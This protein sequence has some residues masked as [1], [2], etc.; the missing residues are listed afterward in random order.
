VKFQNLVE[1]T[2]L[3]AWKI[4]IIDDDED[5]CLIAKNM[6]AEAKGRKFL[7][8]WASTYEAGRE[9]L[10]AGQ[11]HAALVDYDLGLHSGIE[12]I[13]EANERGYPAPLILFTGRG[14]YE[15]D[16]EAMQAGATLYLTKTEVNSYLLERT[17]RYAI[18]LKQKEQALRESEA[19]LRTSEAQER[20][21]V[22]EMDALLDA[23][24]ALVW[25]TH[26]SKARKISGNRAGN[27]FLRGPAGE[28]LSRS[29]SEEAPRNFRVLK[30]N[31]ELAP[32]ELPLQLAAATGRPIRNFEEEL[33][34]EDGRKFNLLGNATPLLGEDGNPRGAVSAFI[35]ITE[36]KQMEEALQRSEK[37]FYTAFVASP[38]AQV[39]SRQEDGRIETINHSFEQ[40][41]GY[42]REEVIGKTS[43]ELKMFANPSDREEAVRR[44]RA[45]KSLRDFDVDIQTKSGQIR[46]ASLSIEI[47]TIG[48][49]TFM[50]TVL[51]DITGRKHLE[52]RLRAS[53]ERLADFLDSTRDTFFV[54]DRDWCFTYVNRRFCEM[55]GHEPQEFIGKVYQ[56]APTLYAGTVVEQHFQKVFAERVPVHFQVGGPYT[57][58]WFD[59]SVYPSLDGIAV[60]GV[61]RTEQN[62]AQEVL[63]EREEILRLAL[64]AGKAGAWAWD[65]ATSSLQWSDGYYRVFG[66]EPGSIEPSTAA[67]LSRVHPDDLQRIETVVQEALEQGKQ[68]DEVHRVVWPDGSVRWVRGMSH[69]FYDTEGRPYR[70]AGIAIDVTE[71]KQAEE[72]LAQYATQLAR[73]NQELQNFAFIA[74]HDLQEPLRKIVGFG[75]L[76]QKNLEHQL[77]ESNADIFR[78]MQ[79]AA[80]RMQSMIQE[81]LDLS[82]VNT[83]G[84]PFV[85]VDLN[86]IAAEVISD[87]E[88]QIG[89]T[90]GK[91]LVDPLPTIDADPAQMLRLLQNLVSN[92]I[93][94]HKPDQP[95]LVRISVESLPGQMVSLMVEDNGIGFEMQ[96]F[97]RILEPFQRLNGRSEF[98]GTGMG[99][100]ICKRI[101]ER[102]HGKIEARS[103]PGAGTKFI[104]TLPL[105]QKE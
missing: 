70:M 50:L 5:D 63:R 68:V 59:V 14:N 99:L 78:R 95:P 85:P 52:E 104:V 1:N 34:F 72:T 67:G 51:Q 80:T 9:E 57:G 49:E 96:Y 54:L 94:F 84:Q 20:A 15:V 53:E 12:L 74:S 92:A 40:L 58:R 31:K 73:S 55:L 22:A 97:D 45:D 43:L 38:N 60:F 11:Y 93:K 4:L 77:E 86:Q 30:Q 36:R 102:H 103:E 28:N 26:D 7:V 6:L 61:D 13:R 82:R 76:L 101:I 105:K 88:S 48:S 27:E 47:F 39:I 29:A 37:H 17:I 21:K 41:F 32:E 33:V 69:A 64:E 83:Q 23:V 89:Q 65:P 91:V 56:N 44:L 8:K 19:A 35:D 18:E 25:V 79:S 46:Q 100:A 3:E 98:E 87:L 81:L 16:I 24:P 66:F 75:N 71:Q 2:P 90:R 42:R 10:I 62:Q